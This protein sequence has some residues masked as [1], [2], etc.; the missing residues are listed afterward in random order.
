MDHSELITILLRDAH[1]GKFLAWKQST[2][3]AVA[4]VSR[5]L[6]KWCWS[7][8]MID[9]GHPVDR[10]DQPVTPRPWIKPQRPIP[11]G[12]LDVTSSA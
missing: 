5:E 4:A 6:A 7:L 10:T 1:T 2:N 3:V 9:D 8:A 12:T 11:T